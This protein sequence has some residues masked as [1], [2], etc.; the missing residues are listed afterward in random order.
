MQPIDSNHVFY[1]NPL[2]L[3]PIEILDLPTAAHNALLSRKIK[4]IGQLMFL[5]KDQLSEVSNIGPKSAGVV[6]EK[7]AAH[8][9]QLGLVSPPVAHLGDFHKVDL[10]DFYGV[11]I[12]SNYHNNPIL[13]EPIRGENRAP[14]PK[15]PIS[16][17]AMNCLLPENIRYIGQLV[18]FTKKDLRKFPQLGEKGVD[19]IEKLLADH[20]LSL[21]VY[22][23]QNLDTLD[24][25]RKVFFFDES[26]AVPEK[27]AQNNTSLDVLF[28]NV[29]MQ[30]A[31]VEGRSDDDIIASIRDVCQSAFEHV[32]KHA[33]KIVSDTTQPT[34]DYYKD[35]PISLDGVALRDVKVPI[36][37]RKE[38]T[39]VFNP[40]VGNSVCAVVSIYLH[41]LLNHTLVKLS[42]D[43]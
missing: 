28:L 32:A 34:P 41:S 4:F 38:L 31:L 13:L 42:F 21:G 17:R 7:L 14:N 19:E 15:F 43:R 40:A 1:K 8:N 29:S 33:G 3:K 10:R 2:M 35:H 12:D 18:K 5:D 36:T 30:S 20:G 24:D 25:I 37:Y 39:D 27:S 9:L 26:S 23:T 11:E 16:V 6:I 22:C